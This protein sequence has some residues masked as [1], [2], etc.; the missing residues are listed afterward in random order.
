VERKKLVRK[1]EPPSKR[2]IRWPRWTGF[3]NKTYWDWLTLLT[4]LAAVVVSATTVFYT[5]AQQEIMQQRQ[6]QEQQRQAQEAELQAYIDQT[7]NL[8]ADSEYLRI[9]PDDEIQALARARTFSALEQADRNGKKSIIRFLYDARLIQGDDPAVS[10]SGATLTNVPLGHMDLRSVNLSGTNL[11]GANLKS[12]DL[13]NANLSG[14]E[15]VT[16]EELQQQAASLEGATMPNGQKFE[17]WIK[18]KEG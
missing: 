8:F 2:G 6:A 4:A 11:N 12:T 10:L 17:D 7:M 1:A 3:A 16:N 9:G 5:T 18:D 14:A 13:S 15:G